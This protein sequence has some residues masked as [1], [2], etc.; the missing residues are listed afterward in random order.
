MDMLFQKVQQGMNSQ[1]FARLLGLQL[2]EAKEGQVKVFCSRRE[3]LLQQTGLI[4][5]G[6]VAAVAE[7][8]AGYA[9]LTVLPENW[10]AIG[11]EYKVNFLRGAAGAG[12]TAYS[13]I[14]KNGRR[15][16]VADVEVFDTDTEKMAAKMLITMMPLQ[17]GK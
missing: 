14:I 10:S 1:T 6:V 3:D 11:V 5:G 7:A 15:L 13:R 2:K 9:A 12:I 17:T 4:H 16:I 8:A